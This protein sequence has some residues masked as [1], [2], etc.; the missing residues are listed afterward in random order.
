MRK[1]RREPAQG[2]QGLA[3]S[4]RRLDGAG[5]AV[6]SPDEV[7]AEREPG[8]GPLTQHLGRHPENPP[9]HASAAGREIDAVLV[10][11]AETPRPAARHIQPADHGLLAA[12]AAYQVHGTLDQD[13]PEVRVL[14][15]AEET[16]PG[17]DGYLR[18][19]LDQ[20]RELAVRHAFEDAERAQLLDAHQIVAR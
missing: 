13:P 19:T 12:D 4:G 7:A 2:D 3:L 9:T 11:G 8:V 20:L 10:P 15:L 17:L 14:A 6:Q 1:A 18:T 5:R 16:D